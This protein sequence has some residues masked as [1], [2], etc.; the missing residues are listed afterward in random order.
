[1]AYTCYNVETKDGQSLT[2]ILAAETPGSIT[3]RQALGHEETVQRTNIAS[4]SASRL[5]L[6]PD[7]LEKT[8]SKQDLADLLDFLKGKLGGLP[9]R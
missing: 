9:F 3:L 8:M 6:M 7:E 4:M 5:S 1:M 2:G